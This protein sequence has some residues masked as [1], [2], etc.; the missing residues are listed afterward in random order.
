MTRLM[1][2][3]LRNYAKNNTADEWWTFANSVHTN[4]YALRSLT[5]FEGCCQG[6]KT[7]TQYVEIAKSHLK[8]FTFILDLECLVDSLALLSELLDLQ[9][10]N[11][12]SLYLNSWSKSKTG[13]YAVRDRMKNDTLYNYL[14]DRN[15]KD[16]ELYNWAKEQ[17]LVK[18]PRATT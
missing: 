13:G 12:T 2:S 8:R 9:L 5:S 10:K 14:L 1:S 18:C 4:N 7:D 6:E 16:I 15:A 11:G 3:A 17:A